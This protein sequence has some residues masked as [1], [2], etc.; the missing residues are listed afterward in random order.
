MAKVGITGVDMAGGVV[1]P[2]S[3]HVKVNGRPVA[4]HDDMVAPHGSPP[5]SPSPK[6]VAS[7]NIKVNGIPVAITGDKATCGH[8]LSGTSHLNVN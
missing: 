5:H 8:T 4:L 3:T 2:T 1:L 7:R 6:L